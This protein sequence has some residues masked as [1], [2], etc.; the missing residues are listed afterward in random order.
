MVLMHIRLAKRKAMMENQLKSSISEMRS[1][2]RSRE[3][4][5]SSQGGKR[6]SCWA[7]ECVRQLRAVTL[8]RELATPGGPLKS[9]VRINLLEDLD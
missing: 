9:F 1:M 2:S 5:E 3:W 6:A 4:K 8:L 7:R